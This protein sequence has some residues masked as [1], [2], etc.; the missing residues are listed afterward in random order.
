[1]YP[2]PRTRL[3]LGSVIVRT[4]V[5]AWST[6]V[7]GYGVGTVILVEELA[8][9]LELVNVEAVSVYAV[10]VIAWLVGMVVSERVRVTVLGHG[11]DAP[12]AMEQVLG[13][14]LPLPCELEVHVRVVP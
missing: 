4:T 9:T 5:A 13:D 3:V 6:K 11:S 1:M 12:A 2:A 14:M 8:V 7:L 10:T